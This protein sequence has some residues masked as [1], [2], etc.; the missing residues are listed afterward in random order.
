MTTAHQLTSPGL[1]PPAGASP[2]PASPAL[3]ALR[4]WRLPQALT[5]CALAWALGAQAE[6]VNQVGVSV[7][8][9]AD[10][11]FQVCANFACQPAGGNLSTQGDGGIGVGAAQVDF[12]GGFNNGAAF[13]AAASLGGGLSSPVLKAKARTHHEH[14][15]HPGYST[16]GD[17]DFNASASAA[18][19]QFYTYTGAVAANYAFTFHVDG[20]I[21]GGLANV[22]AF[23]GLFDVDHT[24]GGELPLGVVLTFDVRD[25]N[26]VG[27]FDESF[28]LQT[29]LQPGQHFYLSASL[30][31][32]VGR[33]D[34]NSGE[35]DAYNTFTTALTGG[36]A[37]L[38]SIGFP[39][40]GQ[41]PEPTTLALLATG[42]G[43]CGLSGL[44]RLRLQRRPATPR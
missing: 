30:S 7:T 28:T 37:S 18:G 15:S 29:L 26:A 10:Y 35:A 44:S 22:H 20:V 31:A 43:V 14:G 2:G 23:A 36:D 17:Y 8:G 39:G 12:Q 4:R 25:F 38:L 16:D 19:V 27:P 34:Y 24:F 40:G 11:I 3:A 42:L 41:V 21:G 6:L 5:A 13:N 32:N 9:N 33:A 1:P